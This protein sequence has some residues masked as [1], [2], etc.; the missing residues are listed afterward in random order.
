MQL[1]DAT[2][3]KNKILYK[4]FA[5]KIIERILFSNQ[6]LFTAKGENKIIIQKKVLSKYKLLIKMI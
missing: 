5:C 1:T 4:T 2:N 3:S 6:N